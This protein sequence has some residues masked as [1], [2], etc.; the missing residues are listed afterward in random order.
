MDTS[1]LSKA[2][3]TRIVSD[4]YDIGLKAQTSLSIAQMDKKVDFFAGPMTIRRF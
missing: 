4:A 2:D 1:N 3:V